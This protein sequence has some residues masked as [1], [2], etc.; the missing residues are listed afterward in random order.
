MQP[1]LTNQASAST[2]THRR[3]AAEGILSA[4]FLAL[5][6]LSVRAAQPPTIPHVDE[7]PSNQST[8]IDD[9]KFAKDPFFPKSERWKPKVVVA[10]TAIP[11]ASFFAQALNSVVLK[12]I[13]GGRN[14]RLA[15]INN[16]TVGIGETVE[17]KFNNQLVRMRCIEI[18]D[19]SVLLGVDGSPDTKEIHL[20]SSM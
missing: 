16:R 2:G 8:F 3:R 13:S 15:L 19:K 20:R 17:I 10:V 5:S 7:I 6:I 9:P 4:L 11:D 14:K 12:G 1:H 18:R